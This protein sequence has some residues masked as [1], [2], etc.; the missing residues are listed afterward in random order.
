MT[1]R[2]W[3]R[4]NAM[5]VVVGAF[6]PQRGWRP[7][8]PVAARPRAPKVYACATRTAPPSPPSSSLGE[9]GDGGGDGGV[10]LTTIERPQRNAL[11]SLWKWHY[12]LD[13][14]DHHVDDMR[15]AEHMARWVGDVAPM[16]FLFSMLR[17]RSLRASFGVA[18][19]KPEALIAIRFVRDASDWQ[20]LVTGK[21]VL[22]VDELLLAPTVPEH[23][24]GLVH[25]GVVQAL[26]SLGQYHSMHV[27]FD[28]SHSSDDFDI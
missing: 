11:V 25:A 9:G 1:P 2:M 7:T 20:R 13:E 28:H 26:I 10:F 4:L 19:E 15:A 24:R 27:S 18:S 22:I 8:S 21:H 6:T 16:N 5:L 14:Q 3:M 17:G 23:L 12:E